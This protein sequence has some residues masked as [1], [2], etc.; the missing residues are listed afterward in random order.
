MATIRTIIV[1]L[2]VF[3]GYACNNESSEKK[4]TGKTDSSG[5]VNDTLVTPPSGNPGTSAY[6]YVELNGKVIIIK[7][8]EL[9]LSIDKLIYHVGKTQRRQTDTVRIYVEPGES[10]EGQ[11]LS[12]SSGKLT[13]L[14]IE[15]Q[16]E[17]SISISNEGPHCD[18]NEWKHYYSEWKLIEPNAKGLFIAHSYSMNERK[19]FPVVSIDELK[20]RVR[21]KCGEDWFQLVKNIKTPTEY[22]SNV[23]IS[24]YYLRMTGKHKESGATVKKL[25]IFE[26]PM[27]D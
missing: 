15:Q 8:P 11:Q 3:A 26:S 9:T 22:P 16:Y 13:D 27:G 5:T 2:T 18:L 14:K 12:V 7:F 20:E 25:I 17:T 23:V 24:R 10:P 6:T 19:H 1:F 21:T 4:T